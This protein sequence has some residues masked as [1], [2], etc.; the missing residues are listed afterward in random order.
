MAQHGRLRLNAADAPTKH[1]KPIDHGGVAVRAHQG[2]WIGQGAAVRLAA[3]DGLGQM[4]QVDLVADAGAGRHHAEVV[5]GGLPPAQEA[6]ALLVAGHFQ[7]DVLLEGV[8]VAEAVHHDG[9]V[10][11]QIDGRQRIDDGRVQAGGDQGAAH[12]RQVRHRRDAGEVLHQHP[13]RTVGDLPG[14][15]GVGGPAGHCLN[16]VRGHRAAVLMAQ[17]VLQQDFHRH[18]QAADIPGAG[19]RGD[20]QAEVVVVLTVN[21][22]RSAAAEAVNGHACSPL[23]PPAGKLQTKRRCGGGKSGAF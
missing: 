2:I 5:K 9:M 23:H 18:R 22:Q 17:Q 14:G 15:V 10:D 20:G 6:V 8:R 13:R 3:P 4:L 7:R 19:L 21:G 1:A 16:G 12:G 11:H